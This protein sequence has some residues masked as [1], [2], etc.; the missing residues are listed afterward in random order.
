MRSKKLTRR[1]VIT[2]LVAAL[3]LSLPLAAAC[4]KYV[5]SVYAG[6]ITLTI[7]PS[8][9]YS[10]PGSAPLQADLPDETP[11]TPPEPET[12]AD[13]AE[14]PAETAETPPV[15]GAGAQ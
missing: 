15:D 14:E 1:L 6:S 2:L 9:G 5:K 10:E 13:T 11:E 8:Q 3:L 4:A 7:S 12:A